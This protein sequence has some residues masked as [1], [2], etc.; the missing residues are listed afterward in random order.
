MI[1]IVALDLIGVLIKKGNKEVE[2]LKKLK[3]KYP[4][5]KLVIA[6]N[7]SQDFKQDL[8]KAFP[9]IDK[10]Y[11]SEEMGFRK[12]SLEYFKALLSREDSKAEEVLFIDDSS[13]NTSSAASVGIKTIT[14]NNEDL[15]DLVD[16]FI[17]GDKNE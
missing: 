15:F 3:D 12:P 13:Y 6:S 4:K 17:K 9:L 5:I 16:Q 1:K 14:Y 10:I 7:F 8:K 2:G 11:L